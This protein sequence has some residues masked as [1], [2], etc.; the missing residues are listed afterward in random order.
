[1]PGMPS[2]ILSLIVNLVDSQSLKTLRLTN[3]RLCAISS[4]P[5]AKRHFSERKHVAST[6]S[7]EAL[8]QITAHPF[9][10][11]FVKTVVIS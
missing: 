3:K 10:G 4:G 6:Y 9:F 8:V 2:E 11:K 7:M 5:F 1:L